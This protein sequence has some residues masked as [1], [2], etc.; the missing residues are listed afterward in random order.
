MKEEEYQQYT[1]MQDFQYGGQKKA[2]ECRWQGGVCKGVCSYF[3]VVYQGEDKEEKKGDTDLEKQ[4]HTL[5]ELP[6]WAGPTV[7]KLLKKGY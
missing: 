5:E 7:E 3:K 6:D 1:Y 2:A 4:Y